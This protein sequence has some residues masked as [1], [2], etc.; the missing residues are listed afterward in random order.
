MYKEKLNA[1]LGKKNFL[2]RKE[3]SVGSE[4]VSALH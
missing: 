2:G 1:N 3:D 4:A